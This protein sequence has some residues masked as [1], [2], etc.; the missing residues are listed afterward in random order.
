MLYNNHH[1]KIN[2]REMTMSNNTETVGNLFEYAIELERAAETL[3]RKLEEMFDAYPEVAL[4]WKQ[5]A[6]EESGHAAYLERIRA[7]VDTDRLSRPADG[8]I[9]QKVRQC[10]DAASQTRLANL[11]TLEDAH[12]LATELENSETNAIFEFM[13][14]NFS[15]DELAKSHQFLRTQLNTHIA[16][17]ENEF[18]V[19]FRGKVARQTIPILR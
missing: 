1:I 8:V 19:E 10:L 3:Y 2:A 17:L 18:P 7:G 6:S 16:R 13:I 11:K 14:M 5:Y 4:F 12:Q 15:T 9:L